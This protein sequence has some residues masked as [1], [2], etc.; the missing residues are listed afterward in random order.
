MQNNCGHEER[1]ELYRGMMLC[2]K[3]LRIAQTCYN[4]ELHAAETQHRNRN[5]TDSDFR[6]DLM[7]IT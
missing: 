7:R 3:C 6:T 5:M 1:K 4:T 2:L